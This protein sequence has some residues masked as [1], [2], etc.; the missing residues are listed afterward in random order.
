[1]GN[2][3]SIQ[4]NEDFQKE[5]NSPLRKP[6]IETSSSKSPQSNT[7]YNQATPSSIKKNSTSTEKYKGQFQS[8]TPSPEKY[9]FS[10]LKISISDPTY[11]GLRSPV[12][13]SVLQSR[14]DKRT[15]DPKKFQEANNT[16]QSPIISPIAQKEL[17]SPKLLSV[18]YPKLSLSNYTSSSPIRTFPYSPTLIP[19]KSER[20]SLSPEPIPNSILNTNDELLMDEILMHGH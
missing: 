8:N 19:T 17:E 6:Y 3:T 12:I 14:S 11:P 15:F 20:L 13:S 16:P 10:G 2:T 1:M 4:T 9:N 5:S 7:Y 18:Q